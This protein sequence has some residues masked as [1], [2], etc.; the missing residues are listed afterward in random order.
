MCYFTKWH[1]EIIFMSLICL[2]MIIIGI[3]NL[4]YLIHESSRY[5]NQTCI[6]TNCT[7]TQDMCYQKSCTHDG[8][9]D[10][11]SV[12]YTA[13][14]SAMWN[15]VSDSFERK[16]TSLPTMCSFNETRCYYDSHDQRLLLILPE[17]RVLIAVEYIIVTAFLVLLPILLSTIYVSWNGCAVKVLFQN[18]CSLRSILGKCRSSDQE[19]DQTTR[20]TGDLS[21]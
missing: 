15:G 2:A 1:S 10:V 17:H 9:E 12:C 18:R 7:T 8:C 16:Y 3:P 14:F 21:L 13:H 6:I 11:P 5:S 20:L 4:V 19:V